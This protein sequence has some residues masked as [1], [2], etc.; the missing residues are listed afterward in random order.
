[1]SLIV[2]ILQKMRL[3]Q[4]IRSVSDK[5]GY[6]ITQGAQDPAKNWHGLRSRPIGM[7]L[8]IG[9]CTGSYARDY[10]R[11]E[12]P[13]A[14]IHSFEPSPIAYAELAKVAKASNGMII[15]HNIGLGDKAGTVSFNS[16][17]DFIYSSS[18]LPLTEEN[19]H[20]FPQLAKVETFEVEVKRLDD[21]APS[22]VPSLCEELLIK[23]D[24]QGFENHVIQGGKETI[25][26]ASACLVEINVENFYDGQPSFDTIYREFAALGFSFSGTFDQ[27]FSDT[28]DLLY[29]DAVFLKNR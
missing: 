11:P 10:L 15:G 9:A 3:A 5:L 12:F 4:S 27:Y 29:F 1:M 8:D 22:L 18:I 24:V 7:I 16:T 6:S 28:G 21:I 23:I 13:D 2:S 20:H 26:K 14:V 25:A 17:K 19:V